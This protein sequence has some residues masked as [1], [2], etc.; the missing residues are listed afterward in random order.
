MRKPYPTDLTDEQ[1]DLVA[2]ILPAARGQRIVDIREVVNAILY[3]TR[4]GC[5]WRSNR[6]NRS[7]DSTECWGWPAFAVGGEAVA[8]VLQRVP[9]L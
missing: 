1:W 5:Q 7:P 3:I 2:P 8:Q 6:C 4:S 9:V